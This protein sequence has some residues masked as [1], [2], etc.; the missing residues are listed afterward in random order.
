MTAPSSRLH[1]FALIATLYVSQAVPLGFFTVA[2]PAILRRE[3][4]GLESVGLLSALA[5]PWLLKFL[6]APVVDRFGSRRGHFKSWILPLQLLSILAVAWIS[7]LDV[8]QIDGAALPW[9]VT[10]GAIFMIA[11]ATQDIA[12]DGLAV[13]VVDARERGRANGIQVGGYYLGQIAGG[14]LVLVVFATLGWSAAVL[15]MAVVLALAFLPAW[16]FREPPKPA[17]VLDARIDFAALRRFVMRPGGKAWLGILIAFRTGE[18]AAFTMLNPMLVDLGLDLDFIGVTV[19]VVASLAAL[20]GAAVASVLVRRLGRKRALI[21]F[22]TLQSFA[23]LCYLVPAN[24]VTEATLL[25]AAIAVAAFASGLATTA[26]Y[27]CMM[28]RCDPRTP[29]TDFTLQ[30][31]LA[32]IGPMFGAIGSGFLASAIGYPSFVVAC[33]LMIGVAL[34]LVGFWMTPQLAAPEASMARTA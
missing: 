22:G 25:L 15:S 7:Q 5:M 32:A 9:L 30:Q 18:G 8:S 24:G 10:A 4:L 19:G 34:A 1:R 6:W 11:S 33:A 26:L 2:V 16:T 14:G 23:V 12:T 13:L 20:F 17:P 29:A 21:V 27:T 28:D 3:G 31:S